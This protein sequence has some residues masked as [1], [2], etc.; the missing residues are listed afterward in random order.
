EDHI[1]GHGGAK[2]EAEAL[3]VPFL[4]EI[5]LSRDI[6]ERS[7][8]GKLSGLDTYIYKSIAAHIAQS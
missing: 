4:G 5:P 1:F 7:D 8:A 2:A 6:R 3:G